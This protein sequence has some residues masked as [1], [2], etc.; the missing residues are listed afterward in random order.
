MKSATPW[1]RSPPTSNCSPTN[2]KTPNSAPRSSGALA[3]GVKRV[4]RLINQMRFLARDALASAGGLPAGAV[5]RR[6]LP[7]SPQTPAG[8]SGAA[9]IRY[10]PAKPIVVTGDR[11]AL[12][13]ALAEVMLNALQANPADPKIGVRLHAES[14]GNG[15]QG[16]QIEVQDNGTGFTPEA[17]KKAFAPFFTTRNVGLGLGLTVA[18]RSSRPTTA[19]WKSSRRSPARPAWCGFCFPWRRP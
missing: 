18:A 11:A 3:D 16:L 7:G 6:S 5:D 19:S 13:H 15:L 17:A 12:K 10:R 14:S 8:Q 1:C 9:Q 2:G 4:T